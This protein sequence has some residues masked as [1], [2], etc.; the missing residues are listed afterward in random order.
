MGQRLSCREPHE[1]ALFGAIKNGELELVKAI[2]VD[3]PTALTKTTGHGRLSALHVAAV[4]GWI[5][6]GFAFSILVLSLLIDSF[7]D[8]FPILLENVDGFF[9]CVLFIVLGLMICRF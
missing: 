1:T 9:S 4:N 5:E 3:D 2:L 8:F 7:S 6:V